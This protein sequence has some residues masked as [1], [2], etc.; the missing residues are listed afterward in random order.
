MRI[1]PGFSRR[2]SGCVVLAGLGCW[3]TASA[4]TQL[5]P[6]PTEPEAIARHCM[7]IGATAG[8]AGA[9]F[10]NN[11]KAAPIAAEGRPLMDAVAVSGGLPRTYL[12]ELKADPS[13]MQNQVNSLIEQIGPPERGQYQSDRVLDEIALHLAQC[14]TWVASRPPE[15]APLPDSSDALL[16]H[17]VVTAAIAQSLGEYKGNAATGAARVA[18][19]G[20]EMFSEMEHTGRL[21]GKRIKERMTPPEGDLYLKSVDTALGLKLAGIDRLDIRSVKLLDERLR[22]CHRELGLQMPLQ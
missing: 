9:H 6:F 20:R 10:T 1:V 14:K 5:V 19:N 15:I 13:L 12:Q 8:A 18:R 3:S 16:D 4:A 7:A 21:K 11:T 2:L 17:C 22:K